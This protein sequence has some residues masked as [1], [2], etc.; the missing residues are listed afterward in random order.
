VV[1]RLSEGD[2][3]EGIAIFSEA[4]EADI[5]EAVT[6]ARKMGSP[7]VVFGDTRRGS[8]IREKLLARASD[9]LSIDDISAGTSH[10]A[11][12]CAMARDAQQ[13]GEREGTARDHDADLARL[14]N[15]LVNQLADRLH[16]P[17][18][19]L[20]FQAI[21]LGRNVEESQMHHVDKTKWP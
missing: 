20:Q 18:T 8:T 10:I 3:P 16:N 15:A 2:R 14:R 12:D 1:S 19:I 4:P 17:L 9:F 11:L 7:A 6:A 21:L 13:R 5:L